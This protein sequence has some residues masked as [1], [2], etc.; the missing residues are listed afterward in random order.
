MTSGTVQEA[1]AETANTP[2]IKTGVTGETKTTE[3]AQDS[4]LGITA[5][6]GDHEVVTAGQ[7]SLRGGITAPLKAEV[8][9]APVPVQQFAQEM[10]GFITGKLEI[11]QKVVSLKRLYPF[12]QKISD[13]LMLR[14]P[15]KMVI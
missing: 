3:S 4:P 5:N 6:E 10:T 9:T 2:L 1:E 11:V 14:S 8:P 15:C 13:K 7:L 12:F